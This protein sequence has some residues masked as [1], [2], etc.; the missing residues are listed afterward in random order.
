T[1]NYGLRYEY[2][3]VLHEDRNLDVIF[4]T[5][6]GIL[7]PPNSDFY[8]SSPHN[9]GPR[10]AFSWSPQKFNNNTELRVGAGDYYGQGQPEDQMKPIESDRVSRTF[11]ANTPYPIDPAAVIANYNIDSPTL[12]Y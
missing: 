8:H 3:S 5:Q 7:L 10:L 6:R 11:P 12:G 4:D 9:F 1:V 2:Y